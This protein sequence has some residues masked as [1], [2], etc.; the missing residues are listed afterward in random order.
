MEPAPLR[1]RMPAHSVAVSAKAQRAAEEEQT[2]IEAYV[3]GRNWAPPL[4]LVLMIVSS[5]MVCSTMTYGDLYYAG[6]AILIM[7]TYACTT[8]PPDNEDMM[9]TYFLIAMVIY[10]AL[11]AFF[12]SAAY[13]RY[14]GLTDG[15]C[16]VTKSSWVCVWNLF[17]WMWTACA[18]VGASL[19]SGY[20]TRLSARRAL[21]LYYKLAGFMLLS[22]ATIGFTDLAVVLSTPGLAASYGY[23]RTAIPWKVFIVIES[24][25]LGREC[26]QT[27]KA[28]TWLRKRLASKTR[29]RREKADFAGT[30]WQEL[31]KTHLFVVCLGKKLNVAIWSA[32]AAEMCASEKPRSLKDLPFRTAPDRDAAVANVTRCLRG[33]DQEP[34]VMW[35]EASTGLLALSVE[36]IQDERGVALFCTPLDSQLLSLAVDTGLREC[37]ERD[38]LASIPEDATAVD[39]AWDALSVGSTGVGRLSA[40]SASSRDDRASCSSL[41]SGGSRSSG[42][43]RPR[44]RAR[45]RPA[46]LPD[47]RAAPRS[48]PKPRTAAAGAVSDE[49]YEAARAEV[50]LF[51]RAR[52]MLK[53][54]KRGTIASPAALFR[55]RRTYH[56]ASRNIQSALATYCRGNEERYAASAHRRNSPPEPGNEQTPGPPCL[57][58]SKTSRS[59]CS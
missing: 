42:D 11:S 16:A 56:R 55:A 26:W 46:T 43:G 8:S 29:T 27:K 3:D 54:T 53:A 59:T 35:L 9:M 2:I 40:R 34:F 51:A 17:F 10:G 50:K 23:G 31:G 22:F 15:S 4:I 47:A 39:D 28:A 30:L 20:C 52:K 48:E 21:A 18:F 57:T 14:V 58:E 37:E 33:E 1:A 6:F 44:P 7:S 36:A 45:R 41:S 12:T 32:G 5:Q 19:A 38:S 24:G 49:A 13:T 25:V